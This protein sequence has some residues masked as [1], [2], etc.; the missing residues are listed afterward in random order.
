L[1]TQSQ[2]QPPTLEQI[3]YKLKSQYKFV[4]YWGDLEKIAVYFR[5]PENIIPY[6]EQMKQEL[7]NLQ[8]SIPKAASR[9]L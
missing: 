8:Q 3:D 5:T 6:I 7:Q 2:T 1:Q 4:D 9:S